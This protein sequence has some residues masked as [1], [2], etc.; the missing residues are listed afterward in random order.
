MPEIGKKI[1]IIET[2]F[3]TREAQNSLLKVFEEEPTEGT[4]F[5]VFTPSAETLLPTLRSRM[6][7][8]HQKRKVSKTRTLQPA[9]VAAL[10]LTLP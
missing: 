10:A 9:L 1:F 6:V 7:I 5:F 2:G 3:F 4:H 8:L